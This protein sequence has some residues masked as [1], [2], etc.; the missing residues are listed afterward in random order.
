M[1]LFGFTVLFTAL[2]I[3]ASADPIELKESLKKGDKITRTSLFGGSGTLTIASGETKQE[4]P[5]KMAEAEVEAEE[6]LEVTDGS[7]TKVKR[8]YSRKHHEFKIPDLGQ[9][10]IT[11][12][13]MLG[14]VVTVELKDGKNVPSCEGVD[15]KD[16]KKEK[17]G[18][19]IDTAMLPGK[20]VSVGDTWE[21]DKEKIKK[22]FGNDDDE[23]DEATLSCKLEAVEEKYGEKCAKISI[24]LSTKGTTSNGNEKMKQAITLEG[25]VWFG[26]KTGRSV[27]MDCKGKMKLSGGLPGGKGKMKIAIDLT[28]TGESKVGEADFSA[29]TDTSAVEEGDEDE[30]DE[31]EDDGKGS[32][33]K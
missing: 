24:K 7:P 10:E 9:E 26:L 27:G 21:G 16:L 28:A 3:F 5:C 8:Y 13:P 30:G 31:D 20:P 4:F 33:M 17:M 19:E 22:A 32:G 14:K 25:S 12:S 23:M 2:A 15:A 18:M 29:K 6:V 11:D 1:R